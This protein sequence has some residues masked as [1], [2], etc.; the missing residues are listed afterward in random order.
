MEEEDVN[1]DAF[2]LP[3]TVIPR[4]YDLAIRFDSLGATTF[5]GT[6]SIDLDL[7]IPLFRQRTLVFHAYQLKIQKIELRYG[8]IVYDCTSY[9]SLNPTSRTCKICPLTRVLRL[10]F[11][12]S[13]FPDPLDSVFPSLPSTLQLVC[14][15]SGIISDHLA[16]CVLGARLR[17][18]ALT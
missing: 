5:T 14:E 16:G 9:Y 15:Y 4:K 8:P 18:H 7:S 12:F 11:P 1:S 3:S 13:A 17:P 10:T 2:R 6:V